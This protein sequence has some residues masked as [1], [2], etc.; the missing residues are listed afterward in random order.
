FLFYA[1][2]HADT[3]AVLPVSLGKNAGEM[4]IRRI[5]LL[6]KTDKRGGVKG[7]LNQCVMTIPLQRV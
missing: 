5:W 2:E 6:T 7:I 4:V 1:G 3:Y